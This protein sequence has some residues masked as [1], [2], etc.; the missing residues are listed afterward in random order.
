MGIFKRDKT[1]L[2]PEQQA[3]KD[4]AQD[5]RVRRAEE[6]LHRA[7]LRIGDAQRRQAKAA[8]FPT[9]G[10]LVV[11]FEGVLNP[12][13]LVVRDDVVEYFSKEAG[14]MGQSV[15]G[16]HMSM[17]LADVTSVQIVRKGIGKAS[18]A[19][20]GPSGGYSVTTD[21]NFAAL[22]HSDIQKRLAAVQAEAD[23]AAARAEGAP[24]APSAESPTTI[25]KQ[26]ADLHRDGILDDEEFAQKKA[27]VLKRL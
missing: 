6:G 24:A 10:A 16:R 2:T 20:T 3:E 1:P 26:L 13:C 11:L 12:K 15:N 19:V 14:V 27:E 22:A 23:E 17:P 18:V 8:G 7:T 5:D 4:R 25:L 21:E 9:E